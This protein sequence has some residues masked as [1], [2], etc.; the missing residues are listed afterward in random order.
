MKIKRTKKS[1][2]AA[3]LAVM[4]LAG[5]GT[6]AAVAVGGGGDFDLTGTVGAPTDAT[7]LADVATVSEAD[8]SKAALDAAPGTVDQIELDEEDGFVIWEVEV[9]GADGVL[10]EL[11]LDA[12]D[13]S[14][15]EQEADDDGKDEGK[16]NDDLVGTVEVPAD[17]TPLTELATV[18]EADATAAALEVAPGTVDMAQLVAE[19]GYVVWD[20]DVTAEDV[21]QVELN[22]PSH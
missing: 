9:R 7:P 14:I 2:A 12:G 22:S 6:A 13:A 20:V 15:L 16:D 10:T 21:S 18:S 4:V 8:A 17:A 1:M 5:G 19:D 11:A 3:G